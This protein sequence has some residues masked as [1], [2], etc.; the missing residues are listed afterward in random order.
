MR[1][2][3]VLS[4][5]GAGDAPVPEAAGDE[6][7]RGQGAAGRGLSGSESAAKDQAQALSRSVPADADWMVLLSGN[8]F[9]L[10]KTVV[11]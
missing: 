6:R 4:N 11:C 10:R 3:T 8:Q 7:V 5:L 1:G 2:G 9:P